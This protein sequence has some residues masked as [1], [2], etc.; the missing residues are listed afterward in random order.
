[1]KHGQDNRS[2]VL[3]CQHFK[4]ALGHPKFPIATSIPA[5]SVLGTIPPSPSAARDVGIEPA[6][7]DPADLYLYKMKVT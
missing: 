1:M 3:Y 2:N 6:A 5:H 7:R 4:A